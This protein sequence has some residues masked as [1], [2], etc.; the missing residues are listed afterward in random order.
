MPIHTTE[1]RGSLVHE[2][3]RLRSFPDLY[4]FYE[5]VT[6]FQQKVAKSV[7]VLTARK[8]A[9]EIIRTGGVF[10]VF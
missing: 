9:R 6:S 8:I 1:D 5:T 10:D 3:D 7:L 4:I 2:T